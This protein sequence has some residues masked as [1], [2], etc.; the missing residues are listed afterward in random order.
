MKENYITETFCHEDV[1]AC[2]EKLKV[3][4]ML[5]RSAVCIH[6]I[7]SLG[8]DFQRLSSAF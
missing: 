6:F 1:R 4:L 3:S 7:P 8:L 2:L 5:G